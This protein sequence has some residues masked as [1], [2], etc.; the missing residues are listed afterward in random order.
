MNSLAERRF[1]TVLLHR[2]DLIHSTVGGPLTPALGLQGT[3]LEVCG[4]AAPLRSPGGEK[5]EET[6]DFFIYRSD[7]PAHLVTDRKGGREDTN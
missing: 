1:T 6:T 4:G 3:D 2:T 5:E 7:L